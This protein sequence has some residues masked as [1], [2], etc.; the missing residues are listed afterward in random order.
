MSEPLTLRRG[1]SGAPL[2]IVGALVCAGALAAGPRGASAATLEVRYGEMRFSAQPGEANSVTVHIPDAP[3]RSDPTGARIIITDAGA[4]LTPGDGSCFLIDAHTAACTGDPSEELYHDLATLSLRLGDM[5]DAVLITQGRGEPALWGG[6]SVKGDQGNDRLISAAFDSWLYGGPGNDVLDSSSQRPPDDPSVY[7]SRL[8]GEQ[9]DDR[10]IGSSGDDVL[11]PD[12]GADYADGGAGDDYFWANSDRSHGA[13]GADVH[14]G[15]D[16]E[17]TIDYAS[18]SRPLFVDL[19]D[20]QPDGASGEDDRLT[21][22]D[23]VTGGRGD[24]V[25][26]GDDG[27]NRLVGSNGRDRLIGRAGDDQLDTGSNSQYSCCRKYVPPRSVDEYGEELASCGPGED[28]MFSGV[29]AR[30]FLTL[31]CEQ[32]GNDLF[33]DGL[34]SIAATSRRTRLRYRVRCPPHRDGTITPVIPV[35]EE[36][37]PQPPGRCSGEIRATRPRNP[38]RLLAQGSFPAGKWTNR[39][40]TARLTRLGQR[41]I[42]RDRGVKAVVT[43]RL[44]FPSQD[45]VPRSQTVAWTTRLRR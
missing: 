33:S 23:N 2:L 21:G 18:R 20:D 37:D 45:A 30:D 42:R 8:W 25:L 15:G 3:P 4:P 27:P 19:A 24:D 31:D 41:L 22:I 6:L 29:T 28:R 32:I 13:F 14:L 38:A 43:L 16:G 26:A 12:S 35:T 5:D 11:G 34:I 44:S 36:Y 9:G 1:R 39:D 10:L 7:T 17:D 40:L